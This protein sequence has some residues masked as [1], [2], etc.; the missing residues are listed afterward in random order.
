MPD[1]RPTS[2]PD[3][4]GRMAR[5]ERVGVVV[6]AFAAVAACNTLV[7]IDDFSD[8]PCEPCIDGAIP[9]DEGVD[10]VA[11]GPA[12]IDGG[13]DT[14]IDAT[15]DAAVDTGI[16]A[17]DSGGGF[18]TPEAGDATDFEWPLWIMPNGSEAGLPNP[19][20]YSPVAGTDAGVF[21]Q[22]THL[23]WGNAQTGISSLASATSWCSPPWR[24]PTRIEL[25][26]ILDTSRSPV[27]VNPVFT[28]IQG[29][30]YWS[31]SVTPAGKSWTVDFGSGAVATT[32]AG[33]AA[34]CIYWPEDA[35]AP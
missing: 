20:K 9:F 32:T 12:A 3:G 21:D 15:A 24:L 14:G 27:L 34:I 31:S 29:L 7:G 23:S 19:A 33:A 11:D 18:T 22:I 8:V 25:V 16:D 5:F 13:M 28:S 17:A 2:G 4:L 10:A 35:G 30:P 26:S 6:L 1:S